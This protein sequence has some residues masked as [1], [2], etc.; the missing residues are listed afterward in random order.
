MSATVEAPYFSR[1]EDGTQRLVLSTEFQV[2]IHDPWDRTIATFLT[3]RAAEDT[4]RQLS[5]DG[6]RA[7][8][9]TRIIDEI[10][11]PV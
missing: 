2:F 9:R 8:W 1:C 7:F 10:A 6:V 3:R 11:V 5:R 4:V